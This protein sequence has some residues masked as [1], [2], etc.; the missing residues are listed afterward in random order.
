M[1]E[2]RELWRDLLEA[3]EVS[4]AWDDYA[5]YRH[6]YFHHDRDRV[7]RRYDS[8]I[9][10]RAI[11]IFF[12]NPNA[13]HLSPMCWQPAPMRAPRSIHPTTTTGVYVWQDY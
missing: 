13:C 11:E 6:T 12:W 8:S 4:A 9:A 10:H 2:Q 1:W 7:Y 3:S 5:A